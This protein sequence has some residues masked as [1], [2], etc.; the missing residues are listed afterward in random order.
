MK[1]ARVTNRTRDVELA[2]RARIADTRWTRLRG[3]LGR[4]RLRRGQGLVISPSRGV[5]TWGM[6]HP[7]DVVLVGGNGLVAAVYPGLEPWSHTGMHDDVEL[8]VELPEGTVEAS[9]T[10]AGDRVE[11]DVVPSAGEDADIGGRARDDGAGAGH[12]VGARRTSRR[13]GIG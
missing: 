10:Q 12:G 11:I 3:L 13:R 4:P 6:S 5:H 2:D 8:A 7:I 9:G 1:A